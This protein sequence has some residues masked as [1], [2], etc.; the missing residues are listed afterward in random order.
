[1]AHRTLELRP[2]TPADAD[3][4]LALLETYQ[5]QNLSPAERRGGFL[6]ARFTVEQIAAMAGDLGIVVACEA[7]RVVAFLCASR[8]D[9]DQAPAIVDAMTAAFPGLPFHGRPLGEWRSFLYGP[10]CIDAPYRGEGL[11]KRMFLALNQPLADRF[12]V[13]AALVSEA[14]PHSLAAHTRGL[15]MED[16]GA[17]SFGGQAFRILAYRL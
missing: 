3:G 15:G 5:L 7:G 1:M 6:S 8:F 11:L 17:F 13:G 14:N 12:E 2:A 16:A 10:V 4:I 9:W